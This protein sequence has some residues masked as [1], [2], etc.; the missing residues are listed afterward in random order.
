[1]LIDGV[2][3]NQRLAFGMGEQVVQG[4]IAVSQLKPGDKSEALM[5]RVE[6]RDGLTHVWLSPIVR[7]Q[8]GVALADP[9]EISEPT[10][11]RLGSFFE[12]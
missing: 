11:G 2:G 9:M 6:S 1:M 5:V 10:G 8:D 12:D 4:E 3:I 7:A